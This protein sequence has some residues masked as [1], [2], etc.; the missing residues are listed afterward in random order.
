M[1]IY[2]IFLTRAQTLLFPKEEF[3]KMSSFFKKKKLQQNKKREN[4]KR[5]AFKK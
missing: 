2:V 5:K 1:F 4:E 3:S